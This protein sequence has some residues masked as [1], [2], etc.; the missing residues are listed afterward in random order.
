M[1]QQNF[2]NHSRLTMGYHGILLGIILLAIIGSFLKLY[3]NWHEGLGG[4]LLPAILL[5]LSVG[6]LLISFF[7]RGFALKAQDR[8]IRA[9]ENLRYFAITGG[10]FDPKL[11]LPQIIA[12]RF[13]P[14]NELVDLAN[15][16]VKENLSAKEIKMAI[17]NWRADNDRV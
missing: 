17:Q 13:A 6:L 9:E 12:L 4:L 16:A 5:L 3:R 10:L 15:R 11:S 8:A 2:K 14:N 1:E 7:A